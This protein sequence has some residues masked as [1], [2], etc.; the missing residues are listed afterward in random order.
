MLRLRHI[1]RYGDDIRD[2]SKLVS[3]A[4]KRRHVASRYDQAH[5]ALRVEAR[6]LQPE[7]PRCACDEC[8]LC[9]GHDGR[10]N[11]PE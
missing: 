8:Y 2:Q 11:P 1:A 10:K 4:S 9:C 7:A 3:R 6:Y 5:P